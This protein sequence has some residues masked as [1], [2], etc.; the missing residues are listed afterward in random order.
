[1]SDILEIR[2]QSGMLDCYVCGEPTEY[3]F[4]IPIYNGDIVSNDFPDD[5]WANGGGGQSVCESCYLKHERGDIPCA[6]R[7]YL[8]RPPHGVYLGSDGAGI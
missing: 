1:M 7:L 2:M 5:M 6:D 8:D 3:R 4:G